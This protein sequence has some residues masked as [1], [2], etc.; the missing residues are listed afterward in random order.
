MY[1]SS[2]PCVPWSVGLSFTVMASSTP[3]TVTVWSSAMLDIV[4]TPPS[5]GVRSVPFAL[6]AKLLV[7]YHPFHIVRVKL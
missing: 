4:Y 5:P 7:V 3:V 1:Q 6:T 2:S